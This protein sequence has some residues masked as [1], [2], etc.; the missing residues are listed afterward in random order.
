MNGRMEKRTI[1][2]KGEGLEAMSSAGGVSARTAPLQESSGRSKMVAVSELGCRAGC[3]S[4]GGT[5]VPGSLATSPARNLRYRMK[6][7][8]HRTLR[9]TLPEPTRVRQFSR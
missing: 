5:W 4:G 2:E 8:E 1:E 6:C 9:N 7:E 3:F